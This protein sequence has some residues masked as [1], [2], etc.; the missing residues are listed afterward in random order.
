MG[1]NGAS[2]DVGVLVGYPSGLA[3]SETSLRLSGLGY[4]FPVGHTLQDVP[5]PS[6]SRIPKFSPGLMIRWED[7]QQSAVELNL[8]SWF[9]TVKEYKA[10]PSR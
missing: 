4:S 7:L 1:F 5:G 2:P 8:W 9:I 6:A 3:S 10:P